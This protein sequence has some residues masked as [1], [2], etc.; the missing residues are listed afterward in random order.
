MPLGGVPETDPLG[1]DPDG[2]V[3]FMFPPSGGPPLPPPGP[4]PPPPEFAL[5]TP[6]SLYKKAAGVTEFETVVLIPKANQANSPSLM[7]SP[8]RVYSMKGSTPSVLVSSPRMLSSAF[9]V[10]S[11]VLEAYGSSFSTCAI[12]SWSKK[13]CPT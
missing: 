10:S 1:G 5:A 4:P 8:R 13:A 6:P 9:S 3:P 7:S 12:R 2:A 11:W